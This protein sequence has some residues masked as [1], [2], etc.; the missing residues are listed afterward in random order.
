MKIQL[1]TGE[2]NELYTHYSGQIN[3]QDVYLEIDQDNARIYINGEI[4]NAMPMDVWHGRTLR[5]GLRCLTLDSANTFLTDEDVVELI[6]RIGEGLMVEWDGNNMVGQQNDDSLKAVDEL[7]ANIAKRFDCDSDFI[8]GWD[9]NNWLYE[10]CHNLGITAETTDSEL[11]VLAD[12]W[13]ER[14]L[15]ENIVLRGTLEYLTDI[16][17]EIIDAKEEGEEEDD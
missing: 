11:V 4:G 17:R 5:I 13:N 15:D 9:A 3:P 8:T 12:E 1:V 16:R 6:A 2:K 7:E 10:D 14:A